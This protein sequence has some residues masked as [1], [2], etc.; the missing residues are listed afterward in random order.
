MGDV[1]LRVRGE[2]EPLGLCEL[3][4]FRHEPY[5]CVDK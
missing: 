4:V 2:Q 3:E 1:Y 5:R